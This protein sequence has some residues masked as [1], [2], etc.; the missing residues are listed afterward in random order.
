[1]SVDSGSGG[2]RAELSGGV[3]VVLVG[4]CLALGVVGSQHAIHVYT[5]G[6]ADSAGGH[7]LHWLRDALLALPIGLLAAWFGV[8]RRPGRSPSTQ[9]ATTSLTFALLTVPGVAAHHYVDQFLAGGVHTHA[10]GLESSVT[11]AGHAL[12][13]LRDALLAQPVAF[14]IALLVLALP[15]SLLGT[16][17][18]SATSGLGR[19]FA[20]VGLVVAFAMI[21]LPVTEGIRPASA[22]TGSDPCSAP[23]TP[24]RSYN[25]SAINVD[26][27]YNKFG[28]VDRLGFMYALDENIGDVRAQERTQQVSTGLRKDPIQPLVLRANLGDCLTINFSNRLTEGLGPSGQVAP[29]PAASIHVHGVAYQTSSAGS[30]VGDN[31]SSLVPPGGSA[32]YKLFI[33][34]S[35]DEGG[36]VFHSHGDS[37]Q[38][39]A[40]GLFGTIIAEPA[41]SSYFDTETGAPLAGSNWEAIIQPPSEPAFREFAIIY[42]EVGDET[43]LPDNHEPDINDGNFEYAPPPQVDDLTK[44]Y[45]PATRALNYRAEPFLRRLETVQK[46]FNRDGDKSQGYGSYAF[47]DPATP[48]PRSYVCEPAKTRLM[49]LGSEQAHVHHLHGG[50]IR[51]RR[52]PDADPNATESCP[53]KVP[54]QNA[55]SIRLDSQTISP[56]ESYSLEHEC[57]AGGCQ[58]AAGDFLYHCHIAEHYIAGMWSF[59][60]VFDTRQDNL[61]TVPGQPPPPQAVDST[62]LIGRTINGKTVV[63]Q[64]QFTNP[65]TQIALETLVE[66]E[67]PPRGVPID[68][69]DATVWD[70]EKQGSTNA[71]LY[72][73]EPEDT[74]CWPNFCSS[75]PGVRP[76]IKFNPESGKYA[77]PLFRPHLGDRPPFSPNGHSGAPWLGET[78]TAE[79]PS[80]LCPASA[81]VRTYNITAITLPITQ[82]DNGDVDQNGQIFVLNEDR[83][84][85]LA[86]QKPAEPLAIRSNVGDCVALTLSSQLVDNAENGFHS[87]VN[88]HT[89]FVQFDPQAS[90]GVITGMSYEQSVNPFAEENRTLTDN[91]PAGSTVIRVDQANR[92]R[93][94]ISIAVG[95]GRPN[96]EIR[97]ITAISRNGRQ[98]TLDRGLNQ[99]HVAGENVGVEF[100]QY[101]WYSDVDS[102]SVFW[103]DHVDGIHSWGHGLFAVHVIEP[104]GS[105]YH[106]P[107]TGQ[108][109]RSGNIVD[110]HTNGDVGVGADRD[111]R[112]FVVFLHNNLR[113]PGAPV[114]CEY[115]SIN[116]RAEP[117]DRRGGGGGGGDPL[118]PDLLVG[119]PIVNPGCPGQDTDDPNI[120]SSVRYG[121]PFTPLPRAYVGD[122]FVIRGVGLGERVEALRFTGHRFAVERFN[123]AGELSDAATIGISERFDLILDGGAGGPGRFPGDYLYYSTR[124]FELANGAWGI[125]RVHDKL[126]PDL[127]PLPDNPPP[128]GSGFPQLGHTGGSPPPATGPGTPCPP[129]A[130]TKAFNV[131]VFRQPLPLG[132]SEDSGGIIYSL[133]ADKAGIQAGTKPTRPLVLRANRGD[134]IEVTLRNDSQK[135]AGFGPAK[136]LFDPQGSYGAAI[137]LN[138][139]S[140]VAPGATYTYRFYAD[141]ELGT[142]LFLNWGDQSSQMHGAY[143]ALIIEPPGSTYTHPTTGAPLESGPVADVHGP[144]GNFRELAALF[145]ASDAHIG[146]NTM[147]YPRDVSGFSSLNYEVA[148]LADRLGGGPGTVFSSAAHGDPSTT[149]L[150]AHAGDPV[151]IRVAVPVSQNVHAFSLEGH[152]WPLEPFLGGSEIIST[153][154]ITSGESLDAFLVGGAGG[155]LASPGDYLYLDHRF[156]FTRAGLWGLLRVLPPGDGT[157]RPL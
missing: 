88:M 97:K 136:V 28:D 122:D 115:G 84:A 64:S 109:V 56:M 130:P 53:K 142:S 65:A 52:N 137:G 36:K 44:T 111:F 91:A 60:R 59:W 102:G 58:A 30:A 140:T 5:L 80:G 150:R 4:A 2:K 106:D 14:A 98:I 70:W 35:L 51:W 49:H 119:D 146:R 20:T 50:A 138:P 71:P 31:P 45:R 29:P 155:P 26:I 104:P 15:A 10:A 9:A 135:R 147:P 107:R 153:R 133:S 7:L 110:I 79:K 156:P 69:E 101:R 144:N 72:V 87:K 123:S 6:L 85:V 39:T 78:Q 154:T 1:M 112:E 103:H 113:G 90:D 48:I 145:H 41:G 152:S 139:D 105:T 99:A 128:S 61:A 37:R 126:K 131:S 22:Q 8:V 76:A 143:G 27:T 32:T 73:G 57:G 83:A 34:P 3:L 33:D 134:C 117:F 124:N 86:G 93:V 100:V 17:R 42:H 108:E 149:V 120:F 47:G 118:A 114:S 43:F 12:H 96:I 68:H 116:L 95:Q 132:G 16:V 24:Q 121:D 63:P 55:Q 21:G 23:G 67:F 157:V 81:P 77:W 18:R 11:I 148:P 19:R 89:H 82:T 151:R 125:L 13:G 66:S 46:A 129:G 92:L 40:H 94:G 74:V 25:V 62:G 54:A 141:K 127:K 38:L 75:T